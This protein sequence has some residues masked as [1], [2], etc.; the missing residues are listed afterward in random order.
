MVLCSCPVRKYAIRQLGDSL[1][2]MDVSFA[3]DNDPDLVRAGC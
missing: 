1:S 2:G 3:S